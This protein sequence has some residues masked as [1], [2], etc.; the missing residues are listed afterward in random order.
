MP[1]VA[2][3]LGRRYG[4][5]PGYAW[6][7][8]AGV[9]TVIVV[10][11]RRSTKTSSAPGNVNDAAAA[12]NLAA[13]QEQAYATGY[14][15]GYTGAVGA[16]PTT[17]AGT[18]YSGPSDFGNVP[19]G[20]S[21]YPATATTATATPVA[22][23]P[24]GPT[25]STVQPV[26]NPHPTA[27]HPAPKKPAPARTGRVAPRRHVVTVRAGDTLAK[28]AAREHVSL[29]ALERANPALKR[30]KHNFGLIHAGEK[31]TVPA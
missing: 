27:P 26:A 29:A 1:D 5:L 14:G 11:H 12:S 21:T 18:A 22:A 2:A 28:I 13:D 30:G 7:A 8:V 16:V 19:T 31:V 23:G 6:V 3:A 4:P 17:G 20:G 9:G 25:S 10:R 24:A 15:D